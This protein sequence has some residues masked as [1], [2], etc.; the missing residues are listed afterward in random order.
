MQFRVCY[1]Q[2]TLLLL[3]LRQA[4]FPIG[5]C[6]KPGKTKANNV[7]FQVNEALAYMINHL[8]ELLHE[9]EGKDDAFPIFMRMQAE[10]CS[11]MLNDTDALAELQR[12][13]IILTD[14]VYPCG[15][16]VAA[17]Y[18]LPL[19]IVARRLF[20]GY[21]FG[22][23][24]P[25]PP[26]YVPGQNHPS[27]EVTGFLQRARNILSYR[28]RYNFFHGLV[29]PIFNEPKTKFNITPHESIAETLSR[30]DLILVQLDFPIEV[31]RPLLPSKS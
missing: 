16:L 7:V 12:A 31:P 20:T 14:S 27:A 25:N 4:T 30:V 2:L 9:A 18:S 29:C 21:M 22:Y 17:K 8:H 11:S 26:S 23:G 10:Y 3:L 5:A 15:N 24:I 19:V 6:E 1:R 13:D 28:E